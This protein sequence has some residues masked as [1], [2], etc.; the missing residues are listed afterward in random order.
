MRAIF[1]LELCV[2]LN[3]RSKNP[4]FDHIFKRHFAMAPLIGTEMKF[5]ACAQLQT[6]PHPTIAKRF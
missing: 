1:D 5:S 4:K 6:I 3:L 2:V